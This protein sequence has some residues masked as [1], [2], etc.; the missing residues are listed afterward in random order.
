M[1]LPRM[2]VSTIG[3]IGIFRFLQQKSQGPRRPASLPTSKRL[4]LML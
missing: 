3:A 2:K 1:A 4:L